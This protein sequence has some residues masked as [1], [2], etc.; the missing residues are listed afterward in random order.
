MKVLVDMNLP[1][2]WV[3]ILSFFN[4]KQGFSRLN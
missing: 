4:Q 2:R 1:P 3:A